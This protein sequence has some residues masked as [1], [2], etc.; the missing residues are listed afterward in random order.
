MLV[1]TAFFEILF[2]LLPQEEVD[3]ERGLSLGDG[4]G[5]GHHDLAPYAEAVADLGD[6]VDVLVA[7]GALLL[8]DLAAGGADDDT[9]LLEVGDDLV[10]R[11]LASGTR[12]GEYPAGTVGG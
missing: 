1:S 4:Y 10:R 2:V 7:L 8:D 11:P 6:L 3:L 5:D 12:P 9:L